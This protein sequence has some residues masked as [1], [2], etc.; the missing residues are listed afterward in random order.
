MKK[1]NESPSG[2]KNKSKLPSSWKQTGLCLSDSTMMRLRLESVK[3]GMTMSEIAEATLA[4][5]LPHNRI[6]S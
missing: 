1:N 3:I 4:K 2:K 5:H 6:A